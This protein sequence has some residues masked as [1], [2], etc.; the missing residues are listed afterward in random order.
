MIRK[1]NIIEGS[2]IFLLHRICCFRSW[3]FSSSFGPCVCVFTQSYLPSC[4][5]Q[6][7]SYA[8]LCSYCSV[9]VTA[10]VQ[11]VLGFTYCLKTVYGTTSFLRPFQS[12]TLLCGELFFLI[13]LLQV[14]FFSLL[15]CPLKSLASRFKRLSLSTFSELLINLIALSNLLFPVLF[16]CR[17]V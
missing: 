10:F 14:P 15:P 2:I 6:E 16:N 11:L 12:S 3:W 4:D 8:R 17:E 7:G 13:F 9:S 1:L 5:V